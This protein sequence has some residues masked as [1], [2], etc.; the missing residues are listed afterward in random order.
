MN[1]KWKAI[2]F[3][4]GGVLIDW[5]PQYLF[6]KVIQDEEKRNFFLQ[7]ICT[8][9]WN[10]EQDAGRPISV[11]TQELITRHPEWKEYIEAYYGRWVEMLAGLIQ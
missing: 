8:P 3:D 5:N 11:A 1:P 4:L 2:I 7:N 6:E 9:D 10:E